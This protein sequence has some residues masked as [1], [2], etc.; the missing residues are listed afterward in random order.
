MPVVVPPPPV[1][2]APP[3]PEPKP[4]T[5]AER[6]RETFAKNQVASLMSTFGELQGKTDFVTGAIATTAV[7]APW[8]VMWLDGTSKVVALIYSILGVIW[9]IKQI[10]RPS[11]PG[12]K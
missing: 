4:L 1:V 11:K 7:L 2:E 10:R 8:W 5:F 6:F 3:A 9:L 12:E